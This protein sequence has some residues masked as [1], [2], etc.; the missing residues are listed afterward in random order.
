VPQSMSVLLQFGLFALGNANYVLRAESVAAASFL[1][2][3]A[4]FQSP[5]AEQAA[6]A[7]AVS[8][9]VALAAFVLL[10]VLVLHQ[11]KSAA[12]SQTSEVDLQL[13]SVH[14]LS[15]SNPRM[16]PQRFRAKFDENS[17]TGKAQKIAILCGITQPKPAAA[18][19]DVGTGSGYIASYFSKLGFGESGTFAVDLVDERRVRSGYQFTQVH[20]TK[21][22]F[23][24][25]RFDFIVSN[26]VIEHVGDRREQH[27]HLTEI[28]R[29]LRE[30]GKLYLAV[31]NRWGF[32]EPHYRLPFLSWL[33][34]ALANRYLR[35]IRG[36]DS[37][38]WCPLSRGE[39]LG[40]LRQNS[41][42][43]EDVTL[44]AVRV[45]AEIEKSGLL[46][47]ASKLPTWCGR[48]L[49]PVIPTLIFVCRKRAGQ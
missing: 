46:R 4:V 14:N 27:A 20:R 36:I 44:Q 11:R 13:K 12:D 39:L 24:D 35:L 19:L 30:D 32:I 40:L 21:L 15:A 29:C 48:L 8:R 5:N 18:I 2:I 31:P 45:A 43:G 22:P 25:Q 37:Y 1:L 10:F 6:I 49:R 23:P 28:S 41:L 26:H 16:G 17:R 47:L 42:D 7:L 9:S 34:K 33:P 38:N 3:I